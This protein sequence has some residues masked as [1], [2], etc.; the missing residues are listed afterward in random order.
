MYCKSAFYGDSVHCSRY[1]IL[2]TQQFGR[3]VLGDDL[4]NARPSTRR[5][6]SCQGC[7]CRTTLYGQSERVQVGHH[8]KRWVSSC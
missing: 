6:H 8:M 5:F 1:S 2:G 4:A 7:N 3:Y